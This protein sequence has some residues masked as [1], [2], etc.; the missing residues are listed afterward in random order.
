M[1]S[2]PGPIYDIRP[3]HAAARADSEARVRSLL[4]GGANLEELDMTGDTPLHTAAMNASA[5]I[6]ALL[7]NAGANINA[8]NVDGY[9]PLHYAV[10]RTENAKL[11]QERGADI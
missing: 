4:D 2:A 11:L 7:L 1:A 3:L 8:R 9:T 6:V 10:E 5:T